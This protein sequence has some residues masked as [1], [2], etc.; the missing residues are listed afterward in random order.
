MNDISR[1][2]KAL[3]GKIL[4]QRQAVLD[5]DIYFGLWKKNQDRWVDMS[6]LSE[7]WYDIEVL[8]KSQVEIEIRFDDAVIFKHVFSEFG[9]IN[10]HYVF[11][12]MDRG[13]CDLTMKIS[14]LKNLP[15]RAINDE[16]VSGMV[17]IKSLRLQEVDLKQRFLSS[18]MLGIDSIIMLPLSRP[19]YSWL[20]DNWKYILPNEYNLLYPPKTN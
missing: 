11:E 12:D 9:P 2:P 14:N 7:F 18:N 13:F 3:Q 1:L 19:V 8:K 16:F 20:I 6:E 5:I 17:E 4:T 15:I 10:I